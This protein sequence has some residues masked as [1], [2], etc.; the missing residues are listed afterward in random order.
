MD[1]QEVPEST[2]LVPEWVA[3]PQ[4]LQE[5]KAALLS[6]GGTRARCLGHIIQ[7]HGNFRV[8]VWSL[9]LDDF[10]LIMI[11]S[12][13][14]DLLRMLGEAHGFPRGYPI[15]WQPGRR[16]HL[17]GFYPKFKNDEMYRTFPTTG[18]QRLSL[19]IKWSGFLFAVLAFSYS[20]KYYWVVTSKNSGNCRD[21]GIDDFTQI[22]ADIIHAE[23]GERLPNAIRLLADSQTYICGE[24]MSLSDQGHGYGYLKDAAMITCAGRYDNQYGPE[25]LNDGTLLQHLP[26]AA[27]QAIAEECG[28]RCVRAVEVPEHKVDSVVSELETSRDFLTAKAMMRLLARH[29]LPVE[30][31]REHQK[32]VDSDTL[33]GLVMQYHY[34]DKPTMRVKWKLPRY[35]FVTMLLRPVRKEQVSGYNLV[36]LSTSMAKRWCRTQE[37]YEYYTMFGM[38]AGTLVKDLPGGELV[39]P[40]ISAGNQVFAM[41]QAEVLQ[42]G[43]ALIAM[44]KQAV[45]A[46]LDTARHVVDV[47]KHDSM[48]CAI[49][50]LASDEDCA[51]LLSSFGLQM[52]LSE[53]VKADI[54]QHTDKAT[55]ERAPRKIFLAWGRQQELRW[56]VSVEDII[57][58]L[59]G[60]LSD[61]EADA[62]TH[63]EAEADTLGSSHVS[64]QR[65]S[66]GE[67]VYAE[68]DR[69]GPS[70]FPSR[71][72]MQI[73]G[74]GRQLRLVFCGLMGSGKSTLC[75][76][77]AH[78][79]GGSWISQDEYTHRGKDARRLAFLEEVKHVMD[80]VD[81]PVLFMDRV[82][83]LQRHREEIVD[84][85]S[86]S[87]VPGDVV[88]VEM[89]HPLDE[90]QASREF[91]LELCESRV[92]GRGEEHPS[93]IG[94][95]HNLNSILRCTAK[96]VEP[97]QSA[98]AAAFRARISVDI[99][100]LPNT[101]AAQVLVDL[102]A[103]GL[104]GQFDVVA[105]L[106]ELQQTTRHIDAPEASLRVVGSGIG[107][108]ATPA[109]RAQSQATQGQG[110]S[111]A[112]P[113]PVELEGP[114]TVR[115]RVCR[116]LGA[117]MHLRPTWYG[118][119]VDEIEHSPG[120]QGLRSGDCILQ[121][122]GPHTHYWTEGRD[123][124][125]QEDCELAFAEF[126]EDGAVVM[127]EP[128]CETWGTV[129][130][131]LGV[132]MD[133]ATL[134]A[135]LERFTVEYEVELKINGDRSTVVLNGPQSAVANARKA[136][137]QL[138]SKHFREAAAKISRVSHW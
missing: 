59:E 110:F 26:P 84:A 86:K 126:F 114:R 92:I 73:S 117:G 6:C 74:P 3:D 31:F 39:A 63:S 14:M 106:T 17:C 50:T 29:G 118:M 8:W 2:R 53:N 109:L 72:R 43:R 22:A 67:G 71:H 101:A 96:R 102:D 44:A 57:A 65:P 125:E 127:V 28:F 24:C 66:Q 95:R 55:K 52:C 138:L 5:F 32:V 120:Q 15:L 11:S 108:L 128:H 49:V 105:C 41:E 19:T 136:A 40:W 80:N 38:V 132:L 111:F 94:T 107:T 77:L 42:R 9:G 69:P 115:I 91:A 76:T 97:V 100:A 93:L 119:V 56:P 33:E 18:V 47:Q 89:R 75:R 112:P 123:L 116:D 103:V 21:S 48:G 130:P 20:A 10:F 122:R 13:D 133:W 137:T 87:C 121:I 131:N 99:T 62:A 81:I 12:K 124:R 134:H 78:V 82:N 1:P 61:R 34:R 4:I 98:E 7:E 60:L 25:S 129:P 135:D 88:L 79:L 16:L 27:M 113:D 46:S 64:T 104:L 23:L 36:N 85:L 83:S 58:S 51:R 54:K 90:G 35:T 70:T 45:S 68:V 37:G 30:Q